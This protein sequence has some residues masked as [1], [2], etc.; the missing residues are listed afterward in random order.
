MPVSSRTQRCCLTSQIRKAVNNRIERLALALGQRMKGKLFYL[1]ALL[2]KGNQ[3]EER[4]RVFVA[5]SGMA[6]ARFDVLWRDGPPHHAQG[7]NTGQVAREGRGEDVSNIVPREQVH[8]GMRA[9]WSTVDLGR[10]EPVSLVFSEES[11]PP[12][13]AGYSDV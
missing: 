10:G 9:R 4:H 7:G 5:G 3:L 11:I 12:R 1:D 6:D 8:A 13:R 2:T